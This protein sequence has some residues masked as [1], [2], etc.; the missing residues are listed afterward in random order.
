MPHPCMTHPFSD[1]CNVAPWHSAP[2]QTLTQ[3]ELG[4]T[5]A[6]V[7]ATATSDTTCVD[8]GPRCIDGTTYQ[9]REATLTS[10]RLCVSCR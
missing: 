1:H 6:N 9:S 4:V 10:D 7:V 8:I 3:C 5:Y 2:R